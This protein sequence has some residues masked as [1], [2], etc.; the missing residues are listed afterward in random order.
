LPTLEQIFSVITTVG[1]S[2]C[3]ISITAEENWALI[4]K[5]ARQ[6]SLKGSINLVDLRTKSEEGRSKENHKG[7]TLGGV[8]F[9]KSFISKL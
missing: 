6:T 3:N 5:V 8:D 7:C 9:E 1:T 4:W 2:I